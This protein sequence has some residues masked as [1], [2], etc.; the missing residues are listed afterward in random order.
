MVH[1]MADMDHDACKCAVTESLEKKRYFNRLPV[2]NWISGRGCW[3]QEGSTDTKRMKGKGA[4]EE[5]KREG[6]ESKEKE[7]MDGKERDKG[8]SPGTCH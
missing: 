8:S 3:D 7:G 5:W 4:R 6:R 2:P 1:R